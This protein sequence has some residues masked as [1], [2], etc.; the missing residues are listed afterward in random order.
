MAKFPNKHLWLTQALHIL[1]YFHIAQEIKEGIGENSWTLA[2]TF[3]VAFFFLVFKLLILKQI[4]PNKLHGSLLSPDVQDA[5]CI[6]SIP[7]GA[8]VPLCHIK[9]GSPRYGTDPSTSFDR[10]TFKHGR[11]RQFNSR[12]TANVSHPGSSHHQSSQS[13]LQPGLLWNQT[14]ACLMSAKPDFGQA[15]HDCLTWLI[16]HKEAS[17]D[18]KKNFK[19]AI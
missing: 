19:T 11:T 18:T 16:Q 6:F 3:L 4:K 2:Q 17:K 8:N 12:W 14:S 15:V 1:Q 10:I 7:I 5:Q 9:E 13:D